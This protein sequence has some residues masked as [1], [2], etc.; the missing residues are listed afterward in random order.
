MR[1]RRPRSA[2]VRSAAARF[3]LSSNERARRP[4][5]LIARA[6]WHQPASVWSRSKRATMLWRPVSPAWANWSW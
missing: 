4:S 5:L 6:R 1:S 3:K 2:G